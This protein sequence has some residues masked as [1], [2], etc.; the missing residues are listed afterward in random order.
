[1]M[2]GHKF[3]S[4]NPPCNQNQCIP[5]V[6]DTNSWARIHATVISCTCGLTQ[7]PSA[8]ADTPKTFEVFG[9]IVNLLDKGFRVAQACRSHIGSTCN[10]L[11][12]PKFPPPAAVPTQALSSAPVCNPSV[13]PVDA[14]APVPV[15]AVNSIGSHLASALTNPAIF[16]Q[17]PVVQPMS[18]MSAHT[19][20][21][22][23]T[24]VPDP[25]TDSDSDDADNEQHFG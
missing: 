25:V 19:A 2:Q 22:D 10:P 20:P 8:T 9:E 5:C 12:Q 6:R 21:T 24:M 1:M 17:T 18:C 4:R 3:W 11:Q 13:Q 15:Q 14:P 23:W 16:S 7:C